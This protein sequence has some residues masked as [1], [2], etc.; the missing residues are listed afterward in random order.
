MS[1]NRFPTSRIAVYV[2]QGDQDDVVIVDSKALAEVPATAVALRSKQVADIDPGTVTQI[3]IQA[4]SDTFSL[5]RST[6]RLGAA[7]TPR[8]KKPTTARSS[9]FLSRIDT[10]QTS[11][12][13][14]PNQVG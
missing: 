1:A 7:G 5:K 11:E 6:E 4:G 3:E 9:S 2:R 13:F 12:F 10:L 8:R 14:R